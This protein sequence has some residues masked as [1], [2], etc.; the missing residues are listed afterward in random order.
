MHGKATALSKEQANRIKRAFLNPSHRLI[1]AIAWYTTER[2][3]AVLRLR[4]GDVY[5][6]P[7]TR[8][9]LPC[10]TFPA[11]IRKDRKTR[12]VEIN[13]DLATELRAF[14]PPLDPTAYLFPSPLRPGEPLSWKAARTALERACKRANLDGLGVRTHSTRRGS[15]TAMARAGIHQR[16]IQSITGHSNASVLAGYIEVSEEQRKAAIATL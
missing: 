8:E 13:A 1:F 6:N 12:Q 16:V 9:P 14:D 5:R 10:I 7:T 2:W 3:G 4:V 15:I 11:R